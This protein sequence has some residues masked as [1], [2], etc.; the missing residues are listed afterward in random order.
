[1][2]TTDAVVGV[3][4]NRS[5][6]SR[7]STFIYLRPNLLLLLLLG[8]PLIWMV[9]VYLGSLAT[10]LVNSFYSL[11]DFTGMIVRQ[12]TFRSYAEL[13]TPSNL[14]IVLRTVGMAAAVT[15]ADA[16]LAFRWL[17]SLPGMPRRAARAGCTWRFCFHFGPAIWCVYTPGS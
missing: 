8:P 5:V 1:M 3:E 10:L 2:S 17:I 6:G 14:D 12:F 9:V 11:D 4:R 13:F 16:V 7:L 15:L